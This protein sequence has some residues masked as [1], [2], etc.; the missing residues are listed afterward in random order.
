MTGHPAGTAL[1]CTRAVGTWSTPLS[2]GRWHSD[3][4]SVAIDCAG[5]TKLR[6]GAQARGG[7]PSSPA[8]LAARG[9]V[10]T[11][12]GT[13]TGAGTTLAATSRAPSRTGRSRLTGRSGQPPAASA[14]DNQHSLAGV[15]RLVQAGLL[16]GVQNLLES[17]ELAFAP[18]V[19]LLPAL[20][21]RRAF[22]A[23]LEDFVD[24]LCAETKVVEG[25]LYRVCHAASTPRPVLGERA[26]DSEQRNEPDRD[27]LPSAKHRDAFVPCCDDLPAIGARTE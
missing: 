10:A 17:C 4:G 19:D 12:T 14:H 26:D 25:S 13:S 27:R 21:P 20:A 9:P 3:H 24:L 16:V 6:R 22:A 18:S 1:Q 7:A 23:D 8:G 5:S 11:S 2:N 15:P